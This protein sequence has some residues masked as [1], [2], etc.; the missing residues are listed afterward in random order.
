MS[1]NE[2]W[3]SS[4]LGSGWNSSGTCARRRRQTDSI[5][6]ARP[7]RVDTAHRLRPGEALVD[8]CCPRSCAGWACHTAARELL[9]FWGREG[10]LIIIGERFEFGLGDAV[11][12]NR[13]WSYLVKVGP[14]WTTLEI[15]EFEGEDPQIRDMPALIS[16]DQMAK[17]QMR[18]AFL[19]TNYRAFAFG[20]EGA[21][22]DS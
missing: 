5:R 10:S 2:G 18:L 8:T 1:R 6:E 17:W 4:H 14:E 20:E 22:A 19:P 15:F 7:Y 12:S 3:T 13:L 21:D 9:G 11:V 16:L